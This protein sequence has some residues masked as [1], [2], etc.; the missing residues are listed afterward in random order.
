MFNFLGNVSLTVGALAAVGITMTTLF[1]CCLYCIHSRRL[2]AIEDN[3]KFRKESQTGSSAIQL[4]SSDGSF[5]LRPFDNITSPY[6]DGIDDDLGLYLPPPPP[7]IVRRTP[8]PRTP[9]PDNVSNCSIHGIRSGHYQQ[10][11]PLIASGLYNHHD[12]LAPIEPL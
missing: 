2:K 1:I 9:L 12:T 5:Q 6:D 7:H 10:S 8:T 3:D 4:D 11:S